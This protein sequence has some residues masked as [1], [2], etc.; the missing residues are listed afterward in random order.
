[1]STSDAN[2]AHQSPLS[3]SSEAETEDWQRLVCPE[4]HQT[5]SR[6]NDVLTCSHCDLEFAI[7]GQIADFARGNYYDEF[8]DPEVLTPAQTEGL[9]NENSGVTSR[10]VDY[11][12]PLIHS[13]VGTIPGRAI[14]VLDSGC[15]NGISVDLLNETGIEAWG[16]DISALRKWQW[17]ERESPNRLVVADTRKL[18]FPDDYFDIAI[19]S[20]VIEHIGVSEIGGDQYQVTPLPDRDESRV[21]FIRELLRVVSPQGKLLVDCPHGAFPIDFWHGTRPGGARFHSLSEGFLPKSREIQAYVRDIGNYRVTPIS[22]YRRLRMKQVGQHWYGRLFQMP[23]A[24]F[25]RLTAVEGFGFLSGSMLNP[26]LVV[27]I[28]TAS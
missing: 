10:V 1:M 5:L 27:K 23:M 24:A 13:M 6:T 28:E 12:A 25:L 3:N 16:N 9:N 22:P 26:Y 21:R 15:G 14:R 7:E 18:P 20:G 4:C 17:R 2:P 11:Y 19:S 8:S